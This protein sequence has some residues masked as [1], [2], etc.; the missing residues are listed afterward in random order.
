MQVSSTHLTI[1][2]FHKL[3]G[4]CFRKPAAVFKALRITYLDNEMDRYVIWHCHQ[5]W[6]LT[7]TRC[8]LCSDDELKDAFAVGTS[9]VPTPLRVGF[10]ADNVNPFDPT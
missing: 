9:L 10:S 5:I 2:H 3:L 8:I 4:L 7:E 6:T 1:Q